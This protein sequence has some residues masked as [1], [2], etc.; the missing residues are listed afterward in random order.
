[1]ANGHIERIAKAPDPISPEPTANFR[2][3]TA[4]GSNTAPATV[5]ASATTL[6]SLPSNSHRFFVGRLSAGF[7]RAGPSAPATGIKKVTPHN[8]ILSGDA[9][10]NRK[11]N[12]DIKAYCFIVR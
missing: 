8:T 2:A 4:P 6:P 3:I 12:R 7:I 11:V 5:P 10:A 1:M 9:P